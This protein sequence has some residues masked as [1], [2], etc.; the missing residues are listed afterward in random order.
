MY[1]IFLKLL[2]EKGVTTADVCKATGISQPTISNWKKRR[3]KIGIATASKIYAA[4]RCSTFDNVC[5]VSGTN[6]PYLKRL[7]AMKLAMN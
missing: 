7:L 5:S 2:E 6:V 3:G 4:S 1:E